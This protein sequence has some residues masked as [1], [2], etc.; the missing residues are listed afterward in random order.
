MEGKL[1]QK[2]AS[3]AK[4]KKKNF[5]LPGITPH[6]YNQKPFKLDGRMELD[7]EFNDRKMKTM[8]YIK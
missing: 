5:K 4:L 6:T 7:V 1:F 3:V 8:V 2:V